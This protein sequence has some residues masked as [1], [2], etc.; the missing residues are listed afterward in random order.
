MNLVY[1]IKSN[2]SLKRIEEHLNKF[3]EEYRNLRVLYNH[4]REETDMSIIMM[5]EKLYVSLREAPCRGFEIS[6]FSI[7]EHHHPDPKYQDY[8]LYVPLPKSMHLKELRVR[9]NIDKKLNSLVSFGLITGD[10]WY[11]EIPL[12]SRESGSAKNHCFIIFNSSV[13]KDTIVLV[14]SVID[15][16]YWEIDG[17]NKEKGEHI[18]HCYWNRFKSPK[19]L[20][21]E[22]EDII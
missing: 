1:V 12:L 3:G 11:I 7:K 5:R 9:E 19:L 2:W 16:T 15:D 4:D 22:S 20:L 10:C 18:F 21:K 6:P 14:K 8:S 13:S 17:L